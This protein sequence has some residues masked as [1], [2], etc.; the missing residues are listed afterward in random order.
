V[1]CDKTAE[2]SIMQFSLK[3]KQCLSSLPAKFDDEILR[4]Y[5]QLEAQTRVGWFPTSQRY[6]SEMMLDGLKLCVRALYKYDY[7]YD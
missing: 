2:A 1:Y 6:I 7:D 3:C 5:R 4:G